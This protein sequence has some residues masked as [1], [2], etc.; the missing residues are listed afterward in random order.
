MPSLVPGF[1][2]LHGNQLEHLRSAVFD[3]LQNNPLDPLEQEIFLVQSNGVAEW[4]K[5]SLAEHLGVCSSTRVTLP[6]RFLWEAYRGMLGADVV[7]RRSAFDRDQL[8]WRLMRLLPALLDQPVF[9]PLENFLQDGLPERRLQLAQKLSDLYDEYQVYRANWLTEWTA[10]NDVLLDAKGQCTALSADQLW[11]AQLWRALVG[12]V[13]EHE[14]HGGRADV[15]NAFIQSINA[16]ASPAGKMPRRVVLFGIS[17]LPYQTLEAL[18]ALAQRIQVILAVPN[19]CRFY[20]GDIISGR[21]LLSAQ[22][23]RQQHRNGRDLSAIPLEQMHTHCHPL[24]AGWGRLGRD[25]IRMLDEFDDADKTRQAFSSMRVD[26]FSEG[27]GDTLLSQLQA[28]IRDLLPLDEHQHPQ[29]DPEDASIQFHI[30][31]SV[32][33]EVEV[34][35]DRLL[36]VFAQAPAGDDGEP[37][38]SRRVRPRDVV[39][40]VP[41][42]E[43]F[44]PS[45]RAVFGQH[46]RNDKR[47][48]PFEIADVSE[49]RI[50]PLL[51][52]LDWLLRLPQQR[53]LQSEVRDLLDVPAIAA[54]FGID[55]KDLPRV[56]QW[57]EASGVRW[58][59]DRNH[60]DALD[61]GPAG[62]QNA[63]I[64]GIRRML[65]G[66]ASGADA[67]FSGIEPFSQVGGLDAALAGSLASFVDCLLRWRTVLASPATPAEW[68]RRARDLRHAFFAAA[69]ERDRLTSAQLEQSLQRWLDD[70]ASAGFEE[71]VPVLIL[72]EAWLGQADE[73]TLNQ[74]FISGGVTFC[75][76]MPMRAVPYRVVCL[77]GMGDGDF[78]RRAQR[79]D[80]DL[81]ALPGMAR[82]G[83]RSRRDDDR[84]LMLEAVLSARDQL[85][86]S[87]VGR[88][89]RD[90]SA[91]PPSVL[92]AQ[93][94]DYL[95]AG[96]QLDLAQLTQ[97]HPLQPFSRR[98]FEQGG[99]RTYAREWR[100]AHADAAAAAAPPMP[101]YAPD[102]Q[103]RLRFADLEYF[104]K[105]PVKQFFRRRLK[106]QFRERPLV[107]MDDEPFALDPLEK[108]TMYDALLADCGPQEAPHEVE[109]RL[110]E[111]VERLE[112]EGRLPIGH[113]GKIWK[114]KIVEELCGARAAWLFLCSRFPQSSG[115]IPVSIRRGGHTIEDWLDRVRKDGQN[116]VWL[117][118]TASKVSTRLDRKDCAIPEKMIG[119][120]VRQLLLSALG[121]Q[122]TGYLVG[123][124]RIL[125]L[126][127]M[128]PADAQVQLD[129]LLSLWTRGM[130]YPLPTACKTALA[131]LAEGDA[132]AKETYNGSAF[133]R[134]GQVVESSE[135]CLA[136]LW[137]DYDALSSHPHYQQVSKALYEALRDWTAHRVSVYPLSHTFD[138]AAAA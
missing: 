90:N 81:L 36:E 59:L 89:V 110:R 74:R 47:Y 67:A 29:P 76:L 51:V 112:R 116:D 119:G 109:A 101:P 54:R 92:V 57:I 124:D 18:G 115:K 61:L 88:S 28:S 134:D 86:V 17:A 111:R 50:N 19:P 68:G 104:M 12:S 117:A 138:Q 14:R 96:W 82:P 6:A 3:W 130:E 16:G 31:H 4:L 93:L 37:D 118:Q 9:A 133:A 120:Y 84:Y 60:R 23:R 53:C 63:W 98:Y 26:L 5:I 1:I 135:L 73:Q 45:I 78:P 85:Y 79:A 38:E 40:M 114:E 55:E 62:D 123:R 95:Q 132:K 105:Q 30:A 44:S 56:A 127:P 20:W 87:W 136:R 10:G 113:L 64:F 137:P 8:T 108:H 80:F 2:T 27:E 121:Y 65:L 97:E 66:Y 42:I 33:R 43:K 48:I 102:A 34:L 103:S 52:A 106:V 122:V 77:L 24:L 72:R 100:A 13:P 107:G 83:D 125:E 70:C 129:V 91:Q 94:R 35:H 69:S 15:H 71:T 49:R 131:L 22:R 126:H 99:V 46:P 32:Q 21:D 7:A 128:E 41:D 58:G 39:V 25:F 11:Q 75:T